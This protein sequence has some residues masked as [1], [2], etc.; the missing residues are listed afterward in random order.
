[1]RTITTVVC[2]LLF[3]CTPATGGEPTPESKAAYARV[4]KLVQDGTVKEVRCEIPGLDG[5]WVL[6]RNEAGTVIKE[7]PPAPV[8]AV[9]AAEPKPEPA[10]EIPKEFL[11]GQPSTGSTQ[12][13]QYTRVCVNGQCYLVPIQDQSQALPTMA[14]LGAVQFGGLRGG[15]VEGPATCASGNCAN[16]VCYPQR[17]GFFGGRW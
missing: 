5:D 17:R 6:R 12:P 11:A 2:L 13:V 16:G 3:S 14:P 9:K 10:K 8:T 15:V 1:M 4:Y 7:R